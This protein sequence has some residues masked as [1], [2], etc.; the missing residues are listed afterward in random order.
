[1]S[2]SAERLIGLLRAE[3]AALGQQGGCLT[4]SVYDTAQ[5]LRFLP[6][7]D[8]RPVV[9]WL[10]QQQHADGGWGPEVQ[11][12]ARHVPTLA[13]V[14]AL[15]GANDSPES[16]G[17]VERGVGFLRANAE[18]WA[19]EDS[20][21]DDIPVAVELILPQLL[22]EASARG[23]ELP[24]RP[25]R[26]LRVLGEKR[27]ALIARMKPRAGTAP[28]HAW[29]AWGVQP[30][31]EVVDGVKSI[32]HSPA[33]TA[34]WLRKRREAFPGGS[35][36][37]SGAEHYLRQAA[38]ATGAG[39]PGV[40]PTVWPIYR[41]EQ[42]WGLLALSTTGLLFHPA[43]QDLI[44][45]HLEDLQRA[46]R[47]EGLGMSD[48]FIFDGD[49][50]S[51]TIS[52]LASAGREVDGRTLERFQREGL[53]ITYA[54]ELQP[55]L[56]TTAHGV[57]ALAK[58]GKDA[59]QSTR[60]LLEKRGDNGVWM[61]DKWHGSWLYTT[62]QVM[63]ALAQT[64]EAAALRAATESLISFQHEDGGWG[65][66][67]TSTLSETAY[68]VHAL[69]GSRVTPG[70]SGVAVRRA[71]QKAAR[72]MAAQEDVPHAVET[73]WIGKELYGPVRVDRAFVLSARLA[74]E[75]ERDVLSR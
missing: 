7:E 5:L 23:L 49:I 41:F 21:P 30:D 9:D 4:P 62:S 26:A 12:L 24:Q 71:L 55:S 6:P 65:V 64:G 61:G 8:P 47:P 69:Y 46:L 10:L 1:M 72:W 52:L 34:L 51:T 57:L 28:V 15:L 35:E 25:F 67:S 18:A 22:D 39:V 20:L 75:L 73:Y 17:A 40:V 66:S 60:F 44:V 45:P 33:A 29:E 31:L 11:P 13:A 70:A 53:F 54:H 74:L 56:T 14:L 68:A 37:L 16:H 27:R 2:P 43:L 59:T 38:E 58:L 48:A 63:I 42:P 50:T 3:L 19:F 32:G 36:E